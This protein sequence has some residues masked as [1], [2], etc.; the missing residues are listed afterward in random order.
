MDDS[1][2]L[3]LRE[4][5]EVRPQSAMLT[6]LTTAYFQPVDASATSASSKAT[7]PISS[8]GEESLTRRLKLPV[9]IPVSLH[10][11]ALWLGNGICGVIITNLND[12]GEIYYR[13]LGSE[14][15]LIVPPRLHTVLFVDDA[16]Q[17]VLWGSAEKLTC[18]II[19]LP[20]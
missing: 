14:S 13:L 1:Q 12:V 3:I 2:I 19:F 11:L 16:S 6:L 17:V 8:S 18:E 15:K 20:K 10:D 9:T 7:L 5:S 4:Q